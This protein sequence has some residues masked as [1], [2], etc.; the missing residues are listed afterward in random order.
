[1]VEQAVDVMTTSEVGDVRAGRRHEQ[2]QS[3]M[4]ARYDAAHEMP[5]R[6]PSAAQFVDR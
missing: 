3:G 5:R 4:V 1:M 6:P 2:D